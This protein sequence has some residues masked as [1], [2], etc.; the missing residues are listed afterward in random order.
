MPDHSNT[1]RDSNPKG[2][3]Q[4]K[5]RNHERNNPE[6]SKSTRAGGRT[7]TKEPGGAI[8]VYKEPKKPKK[9]SSGGLLSRVG[10][11]LKG[12]KTSPGGG[13]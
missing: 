1:G 2:Q 6:S 7:F 5:N 10:S 9:P 11:K 8:Y 13:T 12:L 4:D 3:E